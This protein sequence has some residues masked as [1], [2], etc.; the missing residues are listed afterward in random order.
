MIESLAFSL[1]VPSVQTDVLMI[2]DRSEHE[3]YR[4]KSKT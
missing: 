3:P 2:L 4:S 1:K